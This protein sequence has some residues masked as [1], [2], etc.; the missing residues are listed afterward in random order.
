MLMAAA[1]A[2]TQWLP[3]VAMRLGPMTFAIRP[4]IIG[5]DATLP[6]ASAEK[7]GPNRSDQ[8]VG[9]H[10]KTAAEASRAS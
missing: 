1:P 3:S 8:G 10:G 5:V 6:P 4:V 9:R 2:G 7:H